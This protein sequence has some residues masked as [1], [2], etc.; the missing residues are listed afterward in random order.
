[1]ASV[2]PAAQRAAAV[3]GWIRAVLLLGSL[4]PPLYW[5]LTYSGPYRALAEWQLDASGAY[6]VVLTGVLVALL[7]LL[8][9]ALAVQLLAFYYLRRD[10]PSDAAARAARM[11]EKEGRIVSHLGYIVAGVFFL[12]FG[13]TSLYFLQSALRAGERSH[14]TSASLEAGQRPLSRFVVLQ[15]R[16]RPE[17]ALGSETQTNGS[18]IEEVYVP[19][20][21][22]GWRPGEPVVVYLGTY[23]SWLE[24]YRA[25]LASG[26]F[27]GILR[28][29]GLPGHLVSELSRTRQLP[30]GPVWVLDYRASPAEELTMAGTFGFCA[31][32]VAVLASTIAW[33]RSRRVRV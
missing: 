5:S 14:V 11:V 6:E 10:T 17:D 30:K 32:L 16:L 21:S 25:E 15:G 1:M 19:L 8:P 13:G 31:G 12:G 24:H 20:V 29:D 28:E 33:L 27:E 22:P 4:V 26:S 3:P 2:N 23:A 18:T 7:T 9:A